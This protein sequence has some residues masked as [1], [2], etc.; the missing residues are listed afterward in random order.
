MEVGI[1]GAREVKV[2]NDVHGLDVDTSREEVRTHEASGLSV[3]E[4]S[5]GKF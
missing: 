3:T 5:H 2:D 1:R 4:V